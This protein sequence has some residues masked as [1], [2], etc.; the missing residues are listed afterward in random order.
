MRHQPQS[1]AARRRTHRSL[2]R[3]AG[4]G[5]TRVVA[6][7]SGHHRE[8]RQL[9]PAPDPRGVAAPA[10]LGTA[11]PHRSP[12]GRSHGQSGRHLVPRTRSPRRRGR[13][14]DRPGVRR[15]ARLE[16]HGDGRRAQGG[17]DLPPRLRPQQRRQPDQRL[18]GSRRTDQ[19]L[20][21]HLDRTGH[22]GRSRPCV[23]R[24]RYRLPALSGP[25]RR[26]PGQP[27]D[28]DRDDLQR[29]PDHHGRRLQRPP[30]G[31]ADR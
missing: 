1:R 3:R 12:A 6:I 23:D 28:D 22:R 10:R 18:R 15:P 30:R 5:P 7:R 9:L 26:R 11:L 25:P 14:G 19:R 8:R 13:A 17:T 24:T 2:A 27:P 29:L 4:H 31:P 21:G 20:G 16:R